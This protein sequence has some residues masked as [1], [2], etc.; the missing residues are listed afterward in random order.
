[1][2]IQERLA[3][4]AQ[5]NQKASAAAAKPSA[6]SPVIVPQM[7]V[8]ERL[9][10]MAQSNAP[11]MAQRPTVQPPVLN[12]NTFRAADAQNM[13]QNMAEHPY[14]TSNPLLASQMRQMD[15]NVDLGKFIINAQYPVSSGNV[16][17]DFREADAENT[18][19]NLLRYP[20]PDLWDDPY[21]ASQLKATTR[22]GDR[23][24][25]RK[26]SPDRKNGGEYLNNIALLAGARTPGLDN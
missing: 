2:T 5:S 9:A 21:I 24:R 3:Q 17:K 13:A 4:M 20:T 6:N 15:A 19:Y 26:C 14:N 11:A 10:Q 1:M 8:Q 22:H 16:A 23:Q 12:A 7:S 25:G 18:A